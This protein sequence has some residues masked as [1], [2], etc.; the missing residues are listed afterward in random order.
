MLVEKLH[1]RELLPTSHHGQ[2]EK[3][4]KWSRAARTDRGVHAILNGVSCL[5]SVPQQ[6]YEEGTLNHNR[7][8]L[9]FKEALED[10]PITYHCFKRVTTRFELRK[11]VHTRQYCYICH[12]MFFLKEA[13][14]QLK[15]V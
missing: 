11:L 3:Q 8:H 9:E 5:F 7:L 1:A 12:K 14:N 15:R 4:W 10:T 13:S 2:L 6:F